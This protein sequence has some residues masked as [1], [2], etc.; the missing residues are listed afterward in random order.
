MADPL[1][2]DFP[3]PCYAVVFTSV[4]SD[5]DPDGYQQTAACMPELAEQQPGYL[6]I[7]STR[8]E[9]GVGITVSY[10]C[11]EESIRNRH[12]VVEHR[13]TQRLGKEKWYRRFRLRVC[14]VERAYGFDG[15]D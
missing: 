2:A 14:R 3:A 11:D 5:A 9:E 1:A 8:G 13:E 15:S 6:S 4:A 10:W 7:E 12:A